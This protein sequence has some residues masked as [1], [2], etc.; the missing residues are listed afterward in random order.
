MA[1]PIPFSDKTILSLL[2]G[3]DNVFT[4]FEPVFNLADAGISIGMFML[5]LFYRKEF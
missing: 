4:F 2:E 3:Y 1:I 5:I